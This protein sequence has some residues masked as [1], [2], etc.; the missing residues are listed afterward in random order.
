MMIFFSPS[1]IITSV[2]L[3]YG[4]GDL[5]LPRMATFLLTLRKN[6]FD[7]HG[8]VVQEFELLLAS[9]P[10]IAMTERQNR[11]L[12]EC[13]RNKPTIQT[14]LAQAYLLSAQMKSQIGLFDTCVQA[15]HA[16]YKVQKVK[17]VELESDFT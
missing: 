2:L 16:D 17:L 6:E 3:L 8:N 1:V 14:D 11:V 4:V 7:Y 5:H 9:P 13:V 10:S 12:K 15:A